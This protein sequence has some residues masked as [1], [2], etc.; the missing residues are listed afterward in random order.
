[1]FY[2]RVHPVSE[3]EPKSTSLHSI[4]GMGTDTTKYTIENR[5]RGTQ[6]CVLRKLQ[7][8]SSL[9][10]NTLNIEEFYRLL[11]HCNHLLILCFQHTTH[12]ENVISDTARHR[13]RNIHHHHHHG[14]PN[15]R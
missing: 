5:E 6:R 13:I 7:T 1:M 14:I 4:G 8:L 3:V 12:R 2:S 10:I 9:S 11:R 15:V